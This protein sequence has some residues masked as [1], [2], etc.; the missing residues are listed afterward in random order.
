MEPKI[1][2]RKRFLFLGLTAISSFGVLRYLLGGRRK[3]AETVK[4]LT[5]DGKLVEV[6]IAGIK[7]SGNTISDEEVH[8][9]ITPQNKS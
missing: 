7:K 9:W 3:K 6:N 5:K 4:M 8:D 2:S 1:T